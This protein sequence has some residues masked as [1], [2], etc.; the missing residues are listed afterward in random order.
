MPAPPQYHPTWQ[1]G[2]SSYNPSLREKMVYALQGGLGLGD[3]R[4]GV[5]RAR[6]LTQA[7]EMTPFGL[8][9]G[10]EDVQQAAGRGDYL[11]AGINLAMAGLPGPPIKKGI[12]AFHGSPHDFEKFDLSKIGTGEGAQAYGRGLY[13]AE[14]EGVARDYKKRLTKAD[15][16]KPDE[17]AQAAIA[18]QWDAIVEKLRAEHAKSGGR[19]TE[20]SSNL[21]NQLDALNDHAIEDTLNRKPW[22]KEGRMYE[23]EINADPEQFLDWDKPLSEQT[24]PNLQALL[25]ENNP[26]RHA[27][28]SVAIRQ[29]VFGASDEATSKKLKEAGIP[30]IK[31]LD[32]GSRQVSGGELIDVTKGPD[33]WKSKIRMNR[34][35]GEQYFTT[36]MPFDSQEAATKWAQDKIGNPG[37]RNYVVFDD[38]L[39]DIKRKY[40]I[41]GLFAAMGLAGA[42]GY[43]DDA[44]AQTP[45]MQGGW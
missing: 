37:T 33:G 23:V 7:L 26:D 6:M 5:R 9:T 39:L 4:K 18:P 36:S 29:G 20:V 19:M 2:I 38:K 21:Q 12:R 15:N 3:D 11:G 25:G 22:L 41:S 17:E 1:G 34:A 24:N 13:F 42:A 35:N 28:A 40:G 14:N 31:Y 16:V 27:E 32:Q 45:Q 43:T 8:A 30:G 44:Q 10:L